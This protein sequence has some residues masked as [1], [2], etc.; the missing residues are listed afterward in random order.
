[1][2]GR[3]GLPAL[4]REVVLQPQLLELMA[5][6]AR[7]GCIIFPPVPAFYSRPATLDDL[8][9]GTVGRVLARMGFENRLYYRWLGM[10]QAAEL[11]AVVGGVAGDEIAA[12]LLIDLDQ[13]V[14]PLQD[15]QG[16]EVDFMGMIGG[17]LGDD[18]HG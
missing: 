9:N 3:L 10:K 17:V 12:I 2:R 6:A 7:I 5:Q 13:V 1:M 4:L 16:L 11:H 15:G 14:G 18:L 8:V